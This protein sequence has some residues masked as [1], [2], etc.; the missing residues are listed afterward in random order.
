MFSGEVK[1]Q[2]S[3]V[4]DALKL[5]G[6]AIEEVKGDQEVNSDN[7]EV[8]ETEEEKKINSIITTKITKATRE[9]CVRASIIP[10]AYIN[11]EF[12]ANK[13]RDN[14]KEQSINTKKHEM[15]KFDDYIGITCSILSLI[16]AGQK[17]R[18]SYIIGA[19]N[20]LGKTSFV[21]TALMLMYQ[22]RMRVVPYI[23]LSEIAELRLENE[24][25][26][27]RGLD[28]KLSSRFNGENITYQNDRMDPE[29]SKYVDMSYYSDI[30]DRDYYK[31]PTVIT[32]Q[33]SYS[34]YLNAEILFCFLTEPSSK[35]IESYTLKSVLEIRS[36]KGLPTIV[37]VS[38]SLNP[39]KNHNVIGPL[40]WQEILSYSNNKKSFDRLEHIS[41]FR[42]Q[43]G[44]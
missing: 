5:A 1:R 22:R 20:G 37:M 4:M 27:A 3:S 41:C 9:A 35:E 28:V 12:D 6:V 25:R 40:I 15:I 30:E 33:Y 2:V 11:T 16:R 13:V 42:M 43:R 17:L 21:H 29:R 36:A 19:P 38:T 31:K 32:G 7:L 8:L 44:V 18:G 23:S 24:R 26:L 10:E 39:Y 14:Y 34:E